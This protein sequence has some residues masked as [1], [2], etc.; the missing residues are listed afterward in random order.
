MPFIMGW[1]LFGT[2]EIVE[3]SKMLV[4]DKNCDVNNIDPVVPYIWL[5]YKNETEN[6]IELWWYFNNMKF[7]VTI[8]LSFEK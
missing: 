7:Q 1:E 4:S 6:V 5:T 3:L 2:C 8:F